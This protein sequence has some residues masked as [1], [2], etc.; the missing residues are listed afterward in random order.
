MK[1]HLKLLVSVIIG[2]TL[3][4]FA[5]CA[6]VIPNNF[7]LGG[8]TGISLV[9]QRFIPLR[10]SVFT[11]IINGALFFLGLAFMGRQFAAAAIV[12]TIYYPIIMAVF[13]TMPLAT[14]FQGDR[15]TYA[16]FFSL[17]AGLGLGIV[18]RS[19]GSTGGMDIPPCILQKYRGIPVGTSMMVMDIAI[20][21]LQVCFQGLE[22]LLYSVIITVLMS[23][24][25]D[26][27]VVAGESK[28]EVLIISPRFEEIRQAIIREI[29]TGVTMLDIETGYAGTRQQAVMCIVYAKK[30]PAVRDTALRLDPDAFIIT[31]E[32]KNVHGQGYTIARRTPGK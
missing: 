32:V 23:F 13:E 24:V 14:L 31:T 25:I 11:A 9:L 16:V 7:M 3:M 1:Q 19:G 4:A 20:I 22:G 12:S 21:L 8:S 10:L 27:T 28:V 15:L 30:H 26:H 6:F 5:I 17:M 18:V 29:D 2:N